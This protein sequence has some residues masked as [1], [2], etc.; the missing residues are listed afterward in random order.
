LKRYGIRINSKLFEGN[1][2]NMHLKD[3]YRHGRDNMKRHSI[4]DSS[5]ETS[6][7]LSKSSAIKDIAEIYAYPEKEL[8]Q[9]KVEEFNRLMERR[10]KN[11]PIAYITGEKE[12]YSRLFSV[13]R[14]AL[15]P[16]PETEL[17]VEET[18]KAAQGMERP[19]ILDIGTGSGCV[20]VTLACELKD[21]KIYGADVSP[22]AIALAYENAGRHIPSKDKIQFIRG[23]LAV[24]F[25][26][27]AFDIVISNPPYISEAEFKALPPEIKDYEPC[28]ALIAGEDGLY[29]IRK[30][31]SGVG[32]VLKSGGWCLL[33]IG[34][35]QSPAV[36]TLFGQAGFTEVSSA[37]DINDI[38]RVIRARWK[39]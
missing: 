2:K 33:E 19:A 21:A 18:L 7:L 38:E 34:A 28:N 4:E 6:I 20:A 27:D 5:L 39:K 12:F 30:I 32:N 9:I 16:R 8:D 22:G 25:K 26:N 15:I 10:I 37:K 36:K 14:N 31:I 1:E 24:P 35:G 23:N 29:F 13:N 11:E 17:L 3:L